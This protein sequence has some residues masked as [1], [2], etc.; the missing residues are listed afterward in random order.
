MQFQVVLAVVYGF[1]FV[2]VCVRVCSEC[3]KGGS[4]FHISNAASPGARTYLL[5]GLLKA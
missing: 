2:F 1:V 3:L 4:L 5:S